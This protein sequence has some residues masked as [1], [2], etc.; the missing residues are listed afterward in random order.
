[1]AITPLSTTDDDGSGT[2]GSVYNAARQLAFEA[3][4][5]A[6]LAVL[7]GVDAT[8]AP[9]ASPALTGVPTAPTAAALTNTTQLA[10]TAF[11]TAADAVLTTAIAL[12]APLASP[13]LTGVPTAPTAAALDSTTQ[14]ATTAFATLADAALVSA[15]TAVTYAG[16]NFTATGGGTWTVDSGDQIVFRYIKI[17]R[18][19]VMNLVL[20]TTSVAGTVTNLNVASPVTAAQQTE[21][22][23][24]IFD[25]SGTVMSAGRIA[26]NGA[27]ITIYKVDGSAF[28]ASTNLTYLR[29][30]LA[31][32]W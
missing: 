21:S 9:L 19:C 30:V 23:G 7:V 31:F 5:D 22:V 16:G 15:W 32:E 13:A 14:L 25:N 6:A 3:N 26:I 18:L 20:N 28:T 24:L 4:I 2:T 27:T 12:K 11:A 1:M 29:A 10:T 8:K 17:G